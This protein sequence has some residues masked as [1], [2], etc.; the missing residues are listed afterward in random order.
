MSNLWC[1]V[2]NKVVEAGSMRAASL[3]IA[4]LT[5]LAISALPKLFGRRLG[6]LGLVL[7]GATGIAAA[8]LANRYIAPRLSRAVCRDCGGYAVAA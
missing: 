4:P 2:C 6:T 1:T 5:G 7:N 3:A 8:Y